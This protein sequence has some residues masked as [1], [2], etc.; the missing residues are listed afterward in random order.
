MIPEYWQ[1][2]GWARRLLYVV[3]AIGDFPDP[4]IPI[5]FHSRYGFQGAASQHALWRWIVFLCAGPIRF[6]V[7]LWA[8]L[9]LFCATAFGANHHHS[10]APTSPSHAAL[11]D[12]DRQL[13]AWFD[14]LGLED[15]SHAQLVRVRFLETTGGNKYEPDEPRGFLLWQRSQKCR[16]LLNDLTLVSVERKGKHTPKI[17]AADWRTVSPDTEVNAL[18]ATL[19]KKTRDSEYEDLHQVYMDR[20][21]LPAQ[22]FVLARFCA[23]HGRDDL[24]GRLLRTIEPI[25]QQQHLTME[26]A[27]QRQMGRALDWRATLAMADH[28]TNRHVLAALFQNIADHCPEAYFPE[29]DASRAEALRKMA[30]EDDAHV[31]VEPG[32]FA[33][34]SPEEQARELIFRLRDDYTVEFDPW[35]RPWPSD[36]PRGNGAVDKLAALGRSAAPA[37]LEALQDDRPS[38]D[39]LRGMAA[40]SRSIRELAADALDKIVGVRLWELVPNANTMTEAESWKALIAVATDWWQITQEKG[41]EAWL[42]AEVK[43]GGT[44]AA[45]CLDALTKQ[46]PDDAAKLTLLAIPKTADPRARGEMLMRL[47]ETDT[48]EVNDFLLGEVVNGPTLGNRV[49]AAYLLNQRHRTEGAAAMIDEAAKLPDSLQFEPLPLTKAA[50]SPDM[51]RISENPDSPAQLLMFLLFSDAPSAIHKLQELLP[52]CEVQTRF[53][54]LNE[55]GLRLSNLASYKY[56]PASASTLQA[57]EEFL[58]AEL[59]D[60]TALSDARFNRV[61]MTNMADFAA[62]QL[63]RHW[64]ARYHYSPHASADIRAR[65]LAALQSQTV[66]PAATTEAQETTAKPVSRTRKRK[67]RTTS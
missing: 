54:I 15:F 49:A 4:M 64:P 8:L 44:G 29:E 59:Q 23:S 34:L 36:P 40:R 27:I 66:D 41:E 13:F 35:T 17:N 6:W 26:E 24:A 55:C 25:W 11:S 10:K 67:H 31:K 9:V 43:A 7:A 3:F 61:K 60:D 22:A 16:V 12:E 53:M 46:F 50:P 37:L 30:E 18:L 56:Q 52:R 32:D 47:R 2:N 28:Q 45:A 39:V 42:C 5:H 14:Q 62:V 57:L 48:H 63:N 19:T 58:V 33:H 65:Q 21:D 51:F 20:L 1:T 38:R